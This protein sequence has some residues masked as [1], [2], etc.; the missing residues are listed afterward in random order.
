VGGLFAEDKSVKRPKRKLSPQRRLRLVS[1]SLREMARE[2]LLGMGVE[3][4]EKLLKK[5]VDPEIRNLKRKW[6]RQA[7]AAARK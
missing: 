2:L 7:A 3:P 4:T 1:L 6:K 5:L